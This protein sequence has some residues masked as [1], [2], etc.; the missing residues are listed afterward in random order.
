MRI[1]AVTRAGLDDFLLHLGRVVEEARTTIPTRAPVV[2]LRPREE[3]FVVERDP[4]G[5]WRVAGRAAERVVAMTDLTT[6]DALAYVRDRL[7]RLG[8]DRALTRA[9]VRDGDV[10]CIGPVELEYADDTVPRGTG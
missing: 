6:P 10:V 9:G 8:V 5:A 1:S 3:G 7:R 4:D 2:V